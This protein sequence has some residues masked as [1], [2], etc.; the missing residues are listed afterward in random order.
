MNHYSSNDIKLHQNLGKDAE[1]EETART[2]RHDAIL[3][4]AILALGLALLGIGQ[5]LAVRWASAAAHRQLFMF[6]DLLGIVVTA[7]GL[8]VVAWWLLSLLFAILS[9]ALQKAGKIRPA[10]A[11][12]KFSP[13]F[14]RRLAVALLGINLLGMPL[15]NASSGPCEAGWTSA[16]GQSFSTPVAAQWGAGMVAMAG[17]VVAVARPAGVEAASDAGPSTVQPGWQPREPVADPAPLGVRPPRASPGQGEVVVA[18]GDSLWSI[19][20]RQLGPMANDVDIA[21]RWPEWYAA[22]RA[23]IGDNPGILLPGQILRAPATS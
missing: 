9:A 17:P 7:S 14:M 13:A 21:L 11:I 20:A 22:N 23:V 4:A 5:I 8:G 12:A 3:A 1:M 2:V 6:E 19:A 18:S 15:A 16:S 10:S